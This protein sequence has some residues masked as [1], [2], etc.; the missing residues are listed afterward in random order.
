[1]KMN[2]ISILDGGLFQSQIWIDFQAV[3]NKKTVVFE[4]G[5]SSV[6]GVEEKA[7]HIGKYL[8]VPRGPLSV[9]EAPD[10]KNKEKLLSLAKEKGYTFLRVEPQQIIQ[11]DQLHKI[12]GAR[13]C[14]APYD[15]QPREILMMD[16]QEEESVLLAKM[17][18][19]TR[20]NIRLAAK[21]G[22]EVK[23]TR[24]RIDQEA[25][26]ELLTKT[27]ERKDI[28]FH[29]RGYY[30]KFLTH[31][32]REACELLVAKKDDVVLAG[33]LIFYYRDTAYY[34]HGGSNDTGRKYMAPHFLQWEAIKRA[35]TKGMKQYDFGGVS[36]KEAAPKGKDW[37]GITRFKQGFSP[38]TDTLLFPGSYD[39]VIDVW[40]Y[41]AYRF[42]RTIKSLLS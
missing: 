20:Y 1:M 30:E 5:D 13:F 11:K 2:Q 15:V 7:I 17:K 39:I 35:Q 10:T 41:R 18:S 8:Y 16:I 36:V 42:L 14:K 6:Y 25:F 9:P 29:P 31:F 24:D 19:K 21:H 33:V 12:F 37:T 4:W 28:R 26:F 32:D 3:S 40:H 23:E 27:A 34:L 22:I 38:T